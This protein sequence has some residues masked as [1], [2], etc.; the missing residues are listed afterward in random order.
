VGF[1]VD[2]V[3]LEEGAPPQVFQFALPV[4]L[5]SVLLHIINHP[6]QWCCIDSVVTVLVKIIFR[7]FHVQDATVVRRNEEFDYP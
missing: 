4:S 2:K 3:A 1:V 7:N 5:P 6:S